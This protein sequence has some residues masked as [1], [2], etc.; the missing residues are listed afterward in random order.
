VA[1]QAGTLGKLMFYDAPFW[2]LGVQARTFFHASLLGALLLGLPSLVQAIGSIRPPPPTP[3]PASNSASTS[4][5][6]NLDPRQKLDPDVMLIAIYKDLGNHKLHDALAKADALVA[7]YPT[8]RLGHLV[9]GDIL[10][11]HARPVT[12]FGE[13]S[14]APPDKLADFRSEAQARIRALQQKPDPDLIPRALMQ[15]RDDQTYALVVDT[16]QS[17]LYVYEHHNG[18]IKFHADYYISHGKFGINKIKEGDQ[19]TP[20]GV[21]YITS[22]LPRAKLP[23]FYGSGALPINYPNEWDKLNGRSGSGI[24]LHGTPS[25]SYSRPPV[26]SGGC[27]VL[28]N[29]DLEKLYLSVEAGKTPVVITEK[30]DFVNK[31]RWESERAWAN[32]FLEGWRHDLES[33]DTRRLLANY[34]SHFKSN[35]GED[36]S[37]WFTKNRIQANAASNLTIKL[38]DTT[39]FRYPGNNDLIVATFTQDNFFG[40]NKSTLRKRQYWSKEG[41]QWKV[42]FE[43][44]I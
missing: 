21:Y 17:R 40:K 19:K 28:T 4:T 33:L 3:K 23:D 43:V 9:R 6:P 14:N 34:S 41:A 22:R 27:V 39:F 42:I 26:A 15:L 10:L 25:A 13:G 1:N 29:P 37:T 30:V 38:R 36:L 7:A 31:T 11:A 24:W 18:R 20:I 12:N 2:R 35:T 16:K 44:N 32:K 8:F 5:L